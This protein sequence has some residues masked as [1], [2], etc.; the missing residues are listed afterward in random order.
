MTLQRPLT[1]AVEDIMKACL[2][3]DPGTDAVSAMTKLLD[4]ELRILL[5][6]AQ[7]IAMHQ[8]S[9]NVDC[10]LYAITDRRV[11]REIKQVLDN[12]DTIVKETKFLIP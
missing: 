6:R 1:L 7:D 10:I 8:R 9:V 2:G 11:F 5:N 12:R 4:M 3:N